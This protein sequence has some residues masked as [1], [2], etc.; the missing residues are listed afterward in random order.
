MAAAVAA[1][2]VVVSGFDASV[3]AS[4]AP[5]GSRSDALS[6][7]DVRF[8]QAVRVDSDGTRARAT[9]RFRGREGQGMTIEGPL[10]YVAR[11]DFSTL[12]SRGRTVPRSATGVWMLPRTGSYTLRFDDRCPSN[13]SPGGGEYQ[14]DRSVVLKRVVLHRRDVGRKVPTRTTR[15]T[16]HAGLVTLRTRADA[17]EVVTGDTTDG[18]AG[19]TLVTIQPAGSLL[20]KRFVADEDARAEP[21][22]R[23][24]HLDIGNPLRSFTDQRCGDGTARRGAT[25]VVFSEEPVRLRP[26]R[27][28]RASV[29]ATEP[30]TWSGEGPIRLSLTGRSGE[31]IRL[32][33]PAL[34]GLLRSTAVLRGPNGRRVYQLSSTSDYSLTQTTWQLPRDGR[35]F[36]DLGSAPRRKKSVRATVRSVDA[37]PLEIGVPR[38]LT[39]QDGEWVVALLE[40]PG[41]DDGRLTVTDV[42][43]GSPAG[44]EASALGSNESDSDGFPQPVPALTAVGVGQQILYPNGV[45]LVPGDGD[46]A[47]SVTVRLDVVTR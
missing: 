14:E 24:D 4:S 20:R 36:L 43:A 39:S 46:G 1:C 35:F 31:V 19:T 5:G 47:T 41:G 29:D 38:T 37:V 32:D 21:T 40:G 27:T 6:V 30:A 26:F 9:L 11:C 16:V 28:V 12:Q 25:Y 22:C 10:D 34:R 7:R 45:L 42:A 18:I 8:G 23:T 33:A 17:L 3:A 44:W 13:T 15:T 2:C